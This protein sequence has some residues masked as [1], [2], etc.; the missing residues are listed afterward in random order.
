VIELSKVT[1]VK[2]GDVIRL[3]MGN[4][5]SL[6]RYLHGDLFDA[7]EATFVHKNFVDFTARV[8]GVEG[9]RVTIDRPL[10]TDVRAEWGPAVW[11]FRPTVTEAGVEGMTF[12]FPGVPKKKHLQEEGFN[13]VHL[14]NAVDCWVRDVEVVD[15]DLGVKLDACRG[16]TVSGVVVRAVKRKEPSGHHA[17]WASAHSQ[18]C[19]FKDFDIETRFVHDLSVE[20]FANGC[21]FEKGRGEALNLDHHRNGPYGNLFTELKTGDVSRLWES[22]GR[23]DRGPHTAGWETVW[24]IQWEKGKLPKVPD[25]PLLNVAGVRGYEARRPSDNT[26]WV[27]P[28]GERLEPGNLYEAQLRKRVGSG[29]R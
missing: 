3:I 29:A 10:R 11:S 4:A 22:S 15:G 12:E 16:C 9:R 28:G 13:A 19:L 26:P 6:G 20:G 5:K 27:E 14:V 21:V 24:G 1:G 18:D 8:V 2:K 25:W 7:G 17:L 23:G